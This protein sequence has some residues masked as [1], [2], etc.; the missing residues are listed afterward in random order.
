MNLTPIHETVDRTHNSKLKLLWQIED[1][2][3]CQ[4]DICMYLWVHVSFKKKLFFS[5]GVNL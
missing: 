3:G 1:K 2:Y 5:T 4:M